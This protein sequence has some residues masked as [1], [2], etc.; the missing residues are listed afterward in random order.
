MNENMDADELLACNEVVNKV[1]QAI[2]DPTPSGVLVIT[3]EASNSTTLRYG[4]L[5]LYVYRDG[6]GVDIQARRSGVKLYE[7][8]GA[9]AALLQETDQKRLDELRDRHGKSWVSIVSEAL[10]GANSD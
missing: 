2:K 8:G 9:L 4:Q 1:T 6:R 10:H 7:D 3:N 5:T